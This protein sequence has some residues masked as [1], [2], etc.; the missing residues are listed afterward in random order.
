MTRPH[1]YRAVPTWYDG[2]RFASKAEMRRYIDLRLLERAG[3]I[4][5][6]EL[7]PRFPIEVMNP[8]NGE[9]VLC[10]VYIS[11]FRYVELPRPG[12]ER[13]VIEDVK[14]GPS[15]ATYRLKRRLVEALHGIRISE[16]R[17]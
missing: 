7:Q 9:M 14:G 6:L 10:A 3:H 2:V 17:K 15:T 16:V 5:N 4:R 8:S 12:V 13:I 1:K 11:D